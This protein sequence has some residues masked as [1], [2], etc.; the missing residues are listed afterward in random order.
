M[1]EVTRKLIFLGV[2]IPVRLL[3]A[4]L[5]YTVRSKKVEKKA[6]VTKDAMIGVISMIAFG[7]LAAHTYRCVNSDEEHKGGFGEGVYWNSSVHSMFYFAAA[8]MLSNEAVAPYASIVLLLDLI[9]SG[10]YFMHRYYNH[11]LNPPK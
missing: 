7:L 9:P 5:A 8:L 6:M 4:Y 3:I 11:I 1:D 10:Y 2:C